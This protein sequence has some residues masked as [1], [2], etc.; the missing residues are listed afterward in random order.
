MA[1]KRHH[2]PYSTIVNKL[3][4]SRKKKLNPTS[5]PVQKKQRLNPIR[6]IKPAPEQM[7]KISNEFYQ[8]H[9]KRIW[10]YTDA[11]L[12]LAAD[13]VMNGIMTSDMASRV[14]GIPRTSIYTRVKAL[15]K[16]KS[17]KNEAETTASSSST[18]EVKDPPTAETEAPKSQ[19]NVAE[20]ENEQVVANPVSKTSED[21]DVDV[22][23]ENVDVEDVS[24]SADGPGEFVQVNVSES[25][26]FEKDTEFPIKIEHVDI[27]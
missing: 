20:V 17:N 21:E 1:S 23:I 19:D 7:R 26:M 13:N 9:P 24:F 18:S 5:R 27:E 4:G 12:A 14:Y 15:S 6:P 2:V 3:E 16:T 8:K 10:P 25:P 22:E 11:D